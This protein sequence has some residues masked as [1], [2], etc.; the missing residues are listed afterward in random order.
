MQKRSKIIEA[1]V[2]TWASASRYYKMNLNHSNILKFWD[3]KS[4]TWYKCPE[5]TASNIKDAIKAIPPGAVFVS[6]SNSWISTLIGIWGLITHLYQAFLRGFKIMYSHTGL[7]FG[8]GSQE[9]VEAFPHGVDIGN[10]KKYLDKSHKV[11]VWYNKNLTVD[12]LL[13]LKEFA[14]QQLGKAYDYK[15]F[16]DFIFD[17]K[18]DEN[19]FICTE[20][21]TAAMHSCKAPFLTADPA[22]IQPYDLVEYFENISSYQSGWRKVLEWG[23]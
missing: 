15:A 11:Q 21:V 12:Q 5:P 3:Y 23:Y 16:A 18:E 20:L 2:S 4:N 8:S 22:A 7:Y 9:T 13:S 14:Y 19:A 1:G 17:L 6:M 10:F